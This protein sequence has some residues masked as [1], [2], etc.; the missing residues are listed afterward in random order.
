MN[1]TTA[2]PLDAFDAILSD[3]IDQPLSTYLDTHDDPKEATDKLME[4]Y[5]GVPDMVRALVEWSSMYTD[6]NANLEQAVET[7][8]LEHEQTIIPRLDEA[9][10]TTEKSLPVVT[11]ITASNRWNPVVSSMA[12]RNKE[13]T[14]HNLLTRETRLSQAGISQD[15]LATPNTFVDAIT[16]QFTKLF[17]EDKPVSDDELIALYN[18][19]SALCTYDECST[20]V[21]LRMF[22]KLARDAET[23]FMRGL[24]RRVGQEVRK[25]AVRVMTAA[26]IMP[27][28]MARQYVTRL[29]FLT[30][31]VVA[32]VSMRKP[33]VD[34][35]LNLFGG[36]DRSIR[37]R[38]E[39]ET[40]ILQGVYGSLI[41]DIGIKEGDGEVV[42]AVEEFHCSIEEKVVLIRMLCHVEVFEDILKAL[43]SHKHRTY[44][45]GEPDVKKRTCLCLLLAYAGVFICKDNR[46]LPEM[47]EED[48]TKEKLR[49]EIK[50][51]FDQIKKVAEVCE[52]LKPGCPRF[53]IRGQPIEVLLEGVKSPLI[54]RGVLMWAQE[55]LQGGT[56]LRALL[57]TAPTHLA[58]LEAIASKHPVLQGEVLEVI[59][60]AFM[61]DYPDLDIVQAE[62]LRDKFTKTITGLVRIQM[63]PQIVHMFQTS[64]ADNERVDLAHLRHF[65]DGL[66]Q[67]ISPPF[68]R[69]FAASVMELLN[70]GRVASAIERDPRIISKVLKFREQVAKI[71]LT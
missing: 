19:V 22:N 66:L 16:A 41:G 49:I 51:S 10:A 61:R 26:N 9:L 65:I 7:V 56:D 69:A 70:N 48:V 52:D 24:Y 18:R 46:E 60:F 47:L 30:D 12:A 42:E 25:E 36:T 15:V 63:A 11:A 67:I 1:G 20:I 21:S 68:S 59:R 14:L 3:D 33:I 40:K 32:G 43:F 53:K 64:W 4:S 57:V 35:L 54:A 44:L 50:N 55:G 17:A 8:L 13:S 27:E 45:D 37:R 5:E 38:Y 31:C 28:H 71:G 6:G 39:T 58:F 62:E 29:A 2:S 23:P 34:A